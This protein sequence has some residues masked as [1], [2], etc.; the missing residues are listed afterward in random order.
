MRLDELQHDAEELRRHSTPVES[1]FDAAAVGQSML[2][3]ELVRGGDIDLD[4]LNNPGAMEGNGDDPWVADKILPRSSG[5]PPAADAGLYVGVDAEQ[6][7]DAATTEAPLPPPPTDEARGKNRWQIQLPPFLTR[8]AAAR[9]VPSDVPPVADAFE[10]QGSRRQLN[11][12]PILAM[13]LL[14]IVVL[15]LVVGLLNTQRVDVEASLAMDAKRKAAERAV[16]LLGGKPQA[17]PPPPIDPPKAAG[18]EA[19]PEPPSPIPAGGRERHEAMLS[20]IKTG[21]V[22]AS[23]PP[24]ALAQPSP[25]PA[26]L[27]PATIL[28]STA[29][30]RSAQV[31]VASLPPKKVALTVEGAP[32]ASPAASRVTDPLAGARVSG[33][34]K[35]APAPRHRVYQLRESD[36]EW[37]G[38]VAPADA[39]PLAAGVWAG[40]GD[41][42]RGGWRVAE[43]TSQRLTL[44]GPNGGLEIIRP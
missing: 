29:A 41:L 8:K 7:D 42:L 13:G 32:S 10:G 23:L 9:A 35:G 25:L 30:S 2:D 38:Y 36:G 1:P 5:Q 24:T 43:V 4:P 44:V 34:L 18:V 39:D 28:T 14:G 20:A 6:P 15:A 37:L 26:D 33:A 17:T 31:P 12:A 27:P 19:S 16:G 22:L 21:A 40:S 3:Q 11:M